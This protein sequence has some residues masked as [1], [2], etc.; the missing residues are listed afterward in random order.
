MKSNEYV[1]QIGYL[2]DENTLLKAQIAS[3]MV[4][5]HKNGI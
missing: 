5:N 4:K 2:Q 3:E 1:G